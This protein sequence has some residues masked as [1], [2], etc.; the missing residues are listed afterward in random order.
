[1]TTLAYSL[2]LTVTDAD[3]D[4]LTIVPAPKVGIAR[5][6]EGALVKTHFTGSGSL[7]TFVS[8]EDAPAAALAILQSAGINPDA[9]GTALESAAATLY[10]IFR[11]KEAA[12]KL[13]EEALT[14]ANASYAALDL[15]VVDS[16]ADI[17]SPYAREAWIQCAKA[18]RKLHAGAE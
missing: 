4:S 3:G 13:E 5:E 7:G 17:S 6:A 15:N 18:A 8:K 2:P 12:A 9:H 14:L 16:L 1:M 11:K 10:S